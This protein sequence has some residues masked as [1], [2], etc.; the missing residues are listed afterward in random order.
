MLDKFEGLKMLCTHMGGW[1]SW[2]EVEEFLIGRD[3]YM[4]TSFALG[5]MDDQQFIR[6]VKNHTP[7]RVCFGSDW[8]WKNPGKELTQLDSLDLDQETIKKIKYSSATKFLKI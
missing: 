7:D 1:C 5:Q 8:P 4:E 2:D 6:M 3:V